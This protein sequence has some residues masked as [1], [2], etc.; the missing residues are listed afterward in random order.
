MSCVT[1]C[2]HTLF[3]AT[4]LFCDCKAYKVIQGNTIFMCKFG[5]GISNRDWQAQRECEVPFVID[6][7]GV[8]PLHSMRPY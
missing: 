1:I 7:H 8:H 6:I 3:K 5:S 2:D 4:Y